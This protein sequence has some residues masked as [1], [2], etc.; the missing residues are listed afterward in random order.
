MGSLI[1]IGIRFNIKDSFSQGLDGIRKQFRKVE[2]ATESLKTKTKGL[3]S[4]FRSGTQEASQGLKAFSLQNMQLYEAIS[5]KVPFMDQ[6][7]PMLSNPYLAAAAA[8]VTLVTGIYKLGQHLVK[9]SKE[10]RE[11]QTQ[12]RLL[13]QV[14]GQELDD[15]TA[16]VMGISSVF[17][18]EAKEVREATNAM[19]KEFGI[20]GME[21]AKVIEDVLLATGGNADLDWIKEYSTQLKAAGLNA[22]QSG[23][24]IVKSFREGIYQDKAIDSIKEAN[25]RLKE[26]PKATRDSLQKLGVDVNAMSARIK[27][28]AMTT[29]DALQQISGVMKNADLQAQQEII[30]NLF[31]GPGEDAGKRFIGMLRNMDLEMGKL[32]DMND[33]Y[34]RK[35]KQRLALEEA[36]NKEVLKFSGTFSAVGNFFDTLTLKARLL[37]YQTINQAMAFI[38]AH[39]EQF[40]ITWEYIKAAIAPVGLVLKVAI[41][42]VMQSIKAVAKELYMVWMLWTSALKGIGKLWDWLGGKVSEFWQK[43]GGKALVDRLFGE[44]STWDRMKSKI[45]SSIQAVTGAAKTAFEIVNNLLAGDFDLAS[46][47]W[48]KLKKDFSS[49]LAGKKEIIQVKTTD[50]PK[51]SNPEANSTMAGGGTATPVTPPTPEASNSFG[52]SGSGAGR[53]ITVNLGA[54]AQNV[55]IHVKN[56][57]A[58]AEDLESQLSEL[59]TRV[60]RNAET[61]Y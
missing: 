21:A 16:K 3:F 44:G 57:I 61:A 41:W 55:T 2:T 12:V 32:I 6:L 35:Q 29:M 46:A 13:F 39:A 18:K 23:A 7:G 17:G 9:V 20:T 53:S 27:G 54:L 52:G 19:S 28:G 5:S 10:A 51:A 47:N 31:A 36:I 8:V 49:D 22:E 1:D 14:T 59:L 26:L 58:E 45:L 11:Q 24:L 38:N 60:V 48:D 56:S 4:R 25:L 30:A 37:F 15:L 43:I 40:R 50:T 33:P 42:A 34:I